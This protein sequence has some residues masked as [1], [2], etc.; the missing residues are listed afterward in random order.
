MINGGNER[1]ILPV[2][3]LHFREL[4]DII[5]VKTY[6][7]Y[8]YINI[9]YGTRA[10]HGVRSNKYDAPARVRIL[11]YALKRVHR[12]FY[13]YYKVRYYRFVRVYFIRVCVRRRVCEE[14]VRICVCMYFTKVC[15]H[16]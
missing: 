2:K 7:V 15:V 13:T 5:I 12:M 1:F 4:C 8:Y 3:Y 6:D 10:A 11:V 16:K 14:R 9:S